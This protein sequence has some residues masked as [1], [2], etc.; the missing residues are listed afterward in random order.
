MRNKKKFLLFYL[1]IFF[2]YNIA[3]SGEEINYSSK[4]I[5]IS[6]NGKIISG[7]EDVQILVGK[8]IFIS[9]DAFEYDKTTGLY[10][11][12]NNVQFKDKINNIKA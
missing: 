12:F 9:S 3:F 8:N 6:E 2:F 11:I 4:T 7:E 5:K 10:K 1:I